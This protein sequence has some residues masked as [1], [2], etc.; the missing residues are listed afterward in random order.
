M[1]DTRAVV[2]AAVNWWRSKRPVGWNVWDHTAN[3]TINTTTDRENELAVAVSV[4]VE[5]ME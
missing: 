5:E 2:D 1:S 3:P 4:V